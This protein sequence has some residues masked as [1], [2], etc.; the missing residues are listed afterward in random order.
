M[1]KFS[2]FLLVIIIITG[3]VYY[4]ELVATNDFYVFQRDN[5]ASFTRATI[6][7]KTVSFSS[8]DYSTATN[9][10]LIVGSLAILP[11]FKTSNQSQSSS[12]ARAING[13]KSLT[14]STSEN[15]TDWFA[16][17][18]FTATEKKDTCQFLSGSAGLGACTSQYNL[19]RAYLELNKT[20]IH[21]F[22]SSINKE[23]Y[24][25]LMMIRAQDIPSNTISPF[26]TKNV[27]GFLFTIDKN[28]YVAEIFDKNDEQYKLEFSEINQTEVA[29]V[30][31]RIFYNNN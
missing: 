29:F 25:K 11:P 5:S 15:P 16:D 17:N 7:W 2:L 30:L 20:D 26:E 1:K 24:N 22:T 3:A 4:Q 13:H 18:G 28:N 12:S 31:S 8:S 14:V 19:Y 9:K 6:S 21:V 10:P 27:T 23:L